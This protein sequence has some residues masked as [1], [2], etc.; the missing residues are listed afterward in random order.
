MSGVYINAN[1]VYSATE[2]AI[3]NAGDSVQGGLFVGTFVSGVTLMGLV[4][5]E[6]DLSTNAPWGCQ[7]VL[8]PEGLTPEAIGQGALNTATIVANCATS[9]IAARLA[10]QLVLNGF[11]DWFLPSL[12]ELLEVYTNLASAGLG[13]FANHSYW[14]STQASATQ[15]STVDMNSGNA[16]DHNKSQTNRHTRAM[17][18]YVIDTTTFPVS[19]TIYVNS[20]T[21]TVVTYPSPAVESPA[22]YLEQPRTE[23]ID[24]LFIDVA[25]GAYFQGGIVVTYNQNTGAGTI[26]TLE[27]IEAVWGEGGI[28]ITGANN[29]SNG[30]LNT[31]NILAQDNLRPIAASICNDLVIN[32]YDDWFLPAPLQLNFMYNNLHLSG[33]GN[34]STIAPYWSSRQSDDTNAV[35][36]DFNNGTTPG[37]GKADQ[38]FVRA[39]RS[40]TY[41][42]TPQVNLIMSQ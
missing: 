15:A 37:A 39:M 12:D 25:I 7:G 26:C 17:R 27:D 2:D 13:N 8:I 31:T 38:Y 16:N 32:G 21:A 19:P 3:P 1:R 30:Q 34:F 29:A 41:L 18:Y 42:P 36:F 5:S 28:F 11:S 40:F 14:S 20:S 4:V 10:D 6:S 35:T 23:S 24:N 33:L 22:F 9:G